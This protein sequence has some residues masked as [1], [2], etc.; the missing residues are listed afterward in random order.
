MVLLFAKAL[1][2]H[3]IDAKLRIVGDAGDEDYFNMIIQEAK[4][5]SISELVEYLPMTD[6]NTLAKL[7][8]EADVCFFP[9]LNKTGFSRVPLEAMASGCLVITY[10]NEGSDEVIVDGYSGFLVKQGEIESCVTIISNLLSEPSIYSKVTLNAFDTI[11][12]NYEMSAYIDKIE[13]FLKMV[14]NDF[15]AK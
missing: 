11:K 14:L 6:R 7:Y 5:N 10:G 8:H 9:S 3:N 4:A 15:H 12:R 2:D 1:L 13:S